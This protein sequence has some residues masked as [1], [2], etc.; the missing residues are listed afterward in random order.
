[1]KKNKRPGSEY[2]EFPKHEENHAMHILVG[3]AVLMALLAY[4]WNQPAPVRFY[5]RDLSLHGVHLGQSHQEVLKLRGKPGSDQLT[6]DGYR[7][8]VYS[9]QESYVLRAD[10]VIFMELRGRGGVE[11]QQSQL[12]VGESRDGLEK[13]LGVVAG[14]SPQ[15]TLVTW[16]G[17][18]CQLMVKF[19]AD[20]KA[21]E[22]RIST[23]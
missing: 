18:D 16:P 8:L 3:L 2:D 21:R 12:E 17:P 7:N 19:D 15:V 13:R 22:Y 6:P 1:M 9:P 5:A 4:W 20:W 10:R 23:P 14:R 11:F